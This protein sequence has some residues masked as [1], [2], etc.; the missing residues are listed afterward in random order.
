MARE[1]EALDRVRAYKF[2]ESI[3][4]ENSARKFDQLINECFLEF[5]NLAKVFNAQCQTR[6]IGDH[7]RGLDSTLDIMKSKH[8]LRMIIS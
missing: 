5:L 3:D 4:F 6:P 2:A 8:I 7:I 1:R